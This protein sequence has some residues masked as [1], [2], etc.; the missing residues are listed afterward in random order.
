MNRTRLNILVIISVL[1]FF[2][3]VMLLEKKELQAFDPAIWAVSPMYGPNLVN[4]FDSIHLPVQQ[5]PPVG[6][7]SDVAGWKGKSYETGHPIPTG[8]M[9]GAG[10]FTDLG[11]PNAIIG[12]NSDSF[13]KVTWTG[14][15]S[16]SPQYFSLTNYAAV[17]ASP[18]LQKNFQNVGCGSVT[19][20][21][22]DWSCFDYIRFYYYFNG[23]ANSGVGAEVYQKMSLY[24]GSMTITSQSIAVQPEMDDTPMDIFRWPFRNH[25][26]LSLKYLANQYN[27]YTGAYFNITRIT[28]VIINAVDTDFSQW[29]REP[30]P[31]EGFPSGSKSV[32]IYYD[33]L[34][35]GADSAL[36]EYDMPA[37]T[38]NTA[39]TGII[40]VGARVQW[41][42]VPFA[43]QTPA[44]PIKGY[45][46]YRSVAAGNTGDPYVPVGLVGSTESEYI[47]DKDFFIDINGNSVSIPKVNG[48]QTY[49]YKVLPVVC[50]TDPSY[51]TL[52][53][54]TVNASYHEKLLTEVTEVC[55]Y[56]DPMPTSTITPTVTPTWYDPAMMSP[57]PTATA[58]VPTDLDAAHVYPNPFNPNDGT[59]QFKVAQVPDGTNVSIYSMDGSLVKDG[60]FSASMGYFSWDGRNKNGTK[61]VSGIYY[62]VLKTPDGDTRV[63]RVIICYKCPTVYGQ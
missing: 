12:G 34:T 61:V 58:T 30:M 31:S 48:G 32:I 60:T 24:D 41:T 39:Y 38:I 13:F 11:P 63:Y 54:T 59:G 50:G 3:V 56:I 27:I 1:L 43:E 36:P 16:Y 49:C 28:D 18:E 15:N 29:S 9:Y 26:S 51:D 37:T 47:D 6:S 23:Y 35:L 8:V 33:Y 22:G 10:G 17:S 20:V 57:T 25:V 4:A 46:I 45:H 7:E 55:G 53:A 14:R 21:A 44:V 2:T 19:T 5:F 42:P 62:L 40:P 52:R